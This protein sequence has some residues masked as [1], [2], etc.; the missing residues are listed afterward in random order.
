MATQLTQPE[1]EEAQ[2]EVED[3]V[4]AICFGLLDQAFLESEE[5]VGVGSGGEG[6]T[7][8]LQRDTISRLL[9]YGH[10]RQEC[11]NEYRESDAGNPKT[12]ASQEEGKHQPNL[13]TT[14]LRSD[15][16]LQAEHR[17]PGGQGG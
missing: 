17:R 6:I 14:T 9:P 12:A 10:P 4:V 7:K 11:K 3:P 15:I 13:I 1:G 5:T 2:L 8:A 16:P